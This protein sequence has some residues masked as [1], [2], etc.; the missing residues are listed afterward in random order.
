[1]PPKKVPAASI[2]DEQPK[3]QKLRKAK[4]ISMIEHAKKRSMWAG[5]QS[6]QSIESYVLAKD[7]EGRDIFKT[8]TL[9]YPPALLKVIDEIF[10][11]AIDHATIYPKLVTHINIELHPDATITVCNNGPGILVEK[12]KNLNG[13]EMYSPQLMFSEFLAGDN[14]DDEADSERVVGGQNGIG[15]KLTVILSDWFTVETVDAVNGLYY[16]QT[17]RDGLLKIEPPEVKPAGK[18]EKPYTKICFLPSYESIFKL[19]IKTFRKTLFEIIQTRAWQAA[20]YTSAAVTFNGKAIPINTF[21]DFCQMHTE[22]QVLPVSMAKP[23][24]KHPWDLCVSI[25]SGKEQYVSLVNGVYVPEGGT[26]IKYIQ[27]QFVENLKDNVEKQLKKSKVKFNRNYITNNIF[28]FMR[29]EIPSPQF[30]SQTKEAIKNPIETFEGYTLTETDWKKIWSLLEPAIMATFLKKQMGDIKTRANRG[31][32]DVPKYEEAKYCRDA[33]KCHECGLIVTEGDSAQGTADTGLLAK[34]SPNFNYDYFGTYSIKGVMVNGLK[35]SLELKTGRK[36][37]TAVDDSVLPPKRGKKKAADSDTSSDS[38]E[39]KTKVTTVPSKGTKKTIVPKA[40]DDLS[41]PRPRIPN[42]KLLSNERVASLIKV[43]GLDFNKSYTPDSPIGDKEWKTLRYGFIVGL[44]D[45]DLD[46]F[47]IF[48]LLITFITTYW[49]RLVERDFLRRINTPVMRA[50]PKNKKKV[51]IEFYSEKEARKWVAKLG[52][53]KA[54]AQYT[55]RYYKGLGSHKQAFKEVTQMFKNIDAKICTYELDSEALKTM[56]IYYG[57]ESKTRKVALATPVTRE[58]IESLRLPMSQHFEIDAKLYQRDNILRKL[59]SMVDG[60]V[61]SRRKVFF[62]AR[63]HAK[64]DIKVA[65]LA[66][67]VVGAADY[68]HGE[69]SLVDTITRMAQG[70]PMARNIPLLQPL[71]QFGTRKKGYKDYAAAR[72]THTKFNS[73]IAD[74]IF[75]KEDDFILEYELEGGVRYEPKYYV[76]IIPYVLCESNKIPSHGWA[77]MTYARD[78]KAIFKNVREMIEGKIQKCKKLPMWNK[79]FKG[80]VRKYGDKQYFVGVYE[81]DEQANTVHITELTPGMCSNTYLRGSEE[82]ASKSESA[83]KGIS[84]KEYVEDYEDCTTIEDGIDITLYLAEGAY[85]AITAEDS[86]YGNKVFDCFE[87]YFELKESIKEHINL[88]NE[89]GEVVEY[90]NYEDVF[91]DWYKF[92]KDLYAVR[93]E[94]EIILVTLEIK[95]LKN[96]QRFSQ[97]HD[98]Y[99][100]TNKTAEDKANQILADNKYDILNHTVLENPK[101]TSVKELIALITLPKNGASYNYLLGM[102]YRDLTE[103]AYKKRIKRLKE[104]EDR[105]GYLQ[106]ET[107][108]F[109]GAKIWLHELDELEE[110]VTEGLKT[111]WFY[112]ENVVNWGD[113]EEE[114]E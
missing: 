53:E 113:E 22:Y 62:T 96:M 3:P 78:I 100:I 86:G 61:S 39:K 59:L 101:F 92:R 35:E 74:K 112:G 33:K 99:G 82:K 84:K 15:A 57:P 91:N 14:L 79:D 36:S 16:K 69:E 43:L 21:A 10:V 107:G 60:F 52:E 105:L 63:K 102:S 48:A 80:T 110:A 8:E 45:Q 2:I 65:G 6:T 1:M 9:S 41:L 34:A 11:N 90:K 29:G 106:D 17:F 31:R 27:K 73:Q 38:S 93:V 32:I 87:E 89:N 98:T 114:A 85:D 37:K 72:Y 88:V 13:V 47:N 24:G 75:R 20:A 76:P 50:F 77:I 23:D 95:M 66:S 104:L 64:T 67:A 54:K 44:T 109:T 108:L 94:R 103:G 70:F 68:H 83:R 19:D 71:G 58:P 26:H 25:T 49:P 4:Q 18:K 42:K 28:I 46:G 51:V 40:R 55:F 56:Y 81:Y 97:S 5:S 30:L 12:T 7:E 111:D